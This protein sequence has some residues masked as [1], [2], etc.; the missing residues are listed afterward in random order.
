LA[1]ALSAGVVAGFSGGNEQ[2]S[3]NVDAS[4]TLQDAHG[5]GSGA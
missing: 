3:R 2:K 4:A 1:I 5:K